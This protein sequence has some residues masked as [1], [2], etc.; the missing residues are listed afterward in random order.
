LH[1]LF[2]F[3]IIPILAFNFLWRVAMTIRSPGLESV[4]E[5]LV[6]VALVALAFVA[7]IY[8]LKVQD[9]LIRLEERLRLQR[10]LPA[11]L[12]HHG[13]KITDRQ[14][15]ALRFCDDE[16]VAE[17]VPRIVSGELRGRNAIK[18]AITRWKADDLRV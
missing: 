13:A 10:V 3:F 14:L 1:P 16:E 7:R 5:A 4:R 6:A 17:L 12:A 15:I 8:A 18:R 11:A 9:R 2:H